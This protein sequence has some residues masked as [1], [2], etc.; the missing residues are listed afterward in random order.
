ML[1]VSLDIGRQ[2]IRRVVAENTAGKSFKG[3]GDP[4]AV[5]TYYY[6]IMAGAHA[7][8]SGYVNHRYGNGPLDLLGAILADAKAKD[9]MAFL[10]GVKP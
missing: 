6:T 2:I 9:E 10:H 5:Y 8:I 3:Q 7:L 1:D 4:N